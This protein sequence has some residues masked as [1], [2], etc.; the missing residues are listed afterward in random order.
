MKIEDMTNLFIG[1]NDA[2]NFRVLICALDEIEASEIA[3]QYCFASRMEGTFII[4][5]FDPT[6]NIDCDY[7]LS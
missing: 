2:E 6:V 1:Y 5:E 3:T 7:I 4:K